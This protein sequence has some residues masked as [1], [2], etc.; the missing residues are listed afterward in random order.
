MTGS[1]VAGGAAF[2][3]EVVMLAGHPLRLF[4]RILDEFSLIEFPH[5]VAVPVHLNEVDLILQTVLGVTD[6]AAAEQVTAGENLVREA[7]YALPELDFLAVHVDEH[8]ALTLDGH[9]RIAVIRLFRI[10]ERNA[11]RI[12]CRMTHGKTPL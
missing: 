1:I 6:A 8:G 11:G 3:L 10:V 7:V 12:D 2:T 4:A 5:H 9:D